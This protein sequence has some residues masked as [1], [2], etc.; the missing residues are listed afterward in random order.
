MEQR[1]GEG[2]GKP[3]THPLR[4]K[5]HGAKIWLSQDTSRKNKDSY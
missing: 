3:H 1:P 2:E 5:L 4:L